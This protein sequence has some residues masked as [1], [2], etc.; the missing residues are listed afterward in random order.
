MNEVLKYQYVNKC[1]TLEELSI[2]ILSLANNQGL[3]EGRNENFVASVMS[4]ICKSYCA[5]EH[6]KLTREYGIRQ[7]ALYILFYNNEIN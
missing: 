7:Q 4:H 5:A 3:I 2:V 1:E 6:N